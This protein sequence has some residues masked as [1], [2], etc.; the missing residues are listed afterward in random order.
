MRTSLDCIPCLV[1]QALD[2]IRLITPDETLHRSIL[3]TV[4]GWSSEID[5]AQPPIILAQRIHRYIR[6]LTGAN[7]PY[8][9]A[10]LRLNNLALKLLPEYSAKIT[11]SDDP[12][13]LAA[14]LAIA[15]NVI[16]MGV[17]SAVTEDDIRQSL[18]ECLSGPVLGMQRE[19]KDAA[20]KANSILYLADNAGEIVFDRLLIEQLSPTRVILAVRGTPVLNDATQNDAFAI[21]M[22]Y[23]VRI[24]DNGSDAP[25][26]LLSDCRPDFIKCFDEAELI[27]AKGQGNY[28]SLS[29]IER[30]IFFLFK[31]K[32]PVIAGH[33]GYPVGSYILTRSGQNNATGTTA[34]GTP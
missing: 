12:L 1:R 4:L 5:L 21:G 15:G 2:A 30:P 29:D 9:A 34:A 31:A 13:M 8:H 10:K 19:F 11:A 3:R 25:G 14:Q 24:I 18:E 27:I 22:N 26:T 33:A 23:L 28:E 32:C 7:D 16:D 6:E 20:A 17:K